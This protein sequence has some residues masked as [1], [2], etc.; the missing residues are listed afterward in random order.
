M[1]NLNILFKFKYM[2]NPSQHLNYMNVQVKLVNFAHKHSAMKAKNRRFGD[3]ARVYLYNYQWYIM[4]FVPFVTY[5]MPVKKS[6]LKGYI[7]SYMR[8]FQ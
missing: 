4:A 5:S 6:P 8:M 2:I 7:D 3:L 1:F